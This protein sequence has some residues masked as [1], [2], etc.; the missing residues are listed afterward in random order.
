M[1]IFGYGIPLIFFPFLDSFFLGGENPGK[2]ERKVI[3]QEIPAK[4]ELSDPIWK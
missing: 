3:K 2:K 4:G 1:R